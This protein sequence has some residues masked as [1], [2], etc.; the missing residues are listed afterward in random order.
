VTWPRKGHRSEAGNIAILLGSGQLIISTISHTPRV[1]T[2]RI[3]NRPEICVDDNEV[4]GALVA[5]LARIKFH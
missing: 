1:V 3:A 4:A 5:A 2:A